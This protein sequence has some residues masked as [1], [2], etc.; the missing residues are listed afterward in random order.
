MKWRV[1]F[2][3][4]LAMAQKIVHKTLHFD[5]PTPCHKSRQFV[6]ILDED[7]TALVCVCYLQFLSA[8][9]K[10][11]S[12]SGGKL[13]LRIWIGQN[14]SPIDRYLDRSSSALA[15]KFVSR[16]TEYVAS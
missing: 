7:Q 3:V 8:N 6:P 16:V 14:N 11:M 13:T 10:Q 2:L 1:V 12:A 15:F 4:T 5:N 9:V